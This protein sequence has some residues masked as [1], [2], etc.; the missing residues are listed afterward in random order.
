M[1]M[2]EFLLIT[3]PWVAKMKEYSFKQLN[4]ENIKAKYHKI[5][6]WECHHSLRAQKTEATHAHKSKILFHSPFNTERRVIV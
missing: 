1:A 5:S 4:V 2:V 3:G 6:F